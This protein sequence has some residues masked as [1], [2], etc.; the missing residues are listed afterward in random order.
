MNKKYFFNTTIEGLSN[1]GHTK[2]LINKDGTPK[3]D[4]EDKLAIIEF[5]KTL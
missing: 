2:M 4:H 1:K 3:F 5:L